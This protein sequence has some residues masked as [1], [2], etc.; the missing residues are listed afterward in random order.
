MKNLLALIA[1][2]GL[3]GAAQAQ[4]W[5]ESLN[6]GGD[7]GDLAGT[8]QLV[9]G[10]GSLTSIVGLFGAN[11]VDL[12]IVRVVDP[13]NF[14]ATTVGGTSLDTQIWLFDMAGMGIAHND[15]SPSGGLQSRLQGADV[16][17]TGAFAGSTIASML[18]AGQNYIVGVS[19]YNRDPQDSTPAAIFAN[20]PFNGI[21]SRSGT[22][23]A[24]AGW[25]GSTSASTAAYT[26]TLAGVEYVPAPGAAALLGLG[27]LLISRRRR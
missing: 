15:D 19:R 13:T 17:S 18:V 23:G 24:L 20:S 10:S 8:A 1:V 9:S 25:V 12:Y 11:D 7:A 22:A 2:A 5:N 4:S 27:G 16:F 26:I 21:H 6:G 3:A 14:L